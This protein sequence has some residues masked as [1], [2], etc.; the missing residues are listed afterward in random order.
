[1]TEEPSSPVPVNPEIA[2]LVHHP[3]HPGAR[4]RRP[5]PLWV[6]VIVL[7]V[8]WIVVLVGVAGLVLPGLQGVLTILAGAAILSVASD[9]AHRW[10]HKLLH[11]RWPKVW[12]K[13]ERFRE[14][15]HDWVHRMVHRE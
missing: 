14:K 11:Q 2:Q 12:D 13:I 1:M 5:L 8:G 4:L 7:L 15:T 10:M 3:H 6:R 9:L